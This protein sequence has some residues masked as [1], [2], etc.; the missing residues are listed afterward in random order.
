MK[1]VGDNKY[2]QFYEMLLKAPSAVGMVKGENHVYEM[3]NPLY[4][5]LMGRKDVIGKTVAEVFPEMEEQ[6]I[7]AQLDRVYQTGETYNGKERLIK[8]ANKDTG[9]YA[10]FYLD[11]VYQPYID[12][13]GLIAGVFFFIN[14]R[15]EQVTTKKK[16][17]KSES[18]YRRIVETAQEGIWLLDEFGRTTFVNK[19]LCEILEYSEVEM[20]GK[21]NSFFMDEASKRQ[22]LKALERRKRGV[23]ES[24]EY[25]FISKSGKKILTKVAANPIFDDAE[26]FK[27]SLGMVSDIT[28]KKHLEELLEKSNR[29]ARIGSWEIDVEKNTVYWSDITKE[30]REAPANFI[31]DLSTGIGFFTEGINQKIIAQRVKECM[32][33]G[34]PWDEE[35]QFKTFKGNLKWVRT[36]GEAVFTNGKCSKIYGCFQDITERKNAV[37]KIFRSEAKLKVAQT[38]AQV[39]S[40]EV[41]IFTNTHTWSDEIYRILGMD[42]SV[43]PSAETFLD[44]VH[45]DDRPMASKRVAEAFAKHQDSSFYFQF[46]KEND[47]LGYGLTEWRFEFDKAGNPLYISG[48]LR[49]LTKEKKAENERLKMISDLHQRNNDLEQ[50]SYIVSHNL[51]SPVANIIGL[52]EELKD[53]SHSA[54]V[55][56][57]LGEALISDAH[58]LENVIGDLNTILQTKTEIT[59]RKELVIFSDL[60]HDIELSISNLI[61]KEEVAITTDFSA[62][63]EFNTIKSY[64]Q[65]IFYNLI[66]N[67]I[68]FRQ[69]TVRPLIEISSQLSKNKLILTF[70][71]NGS[72]IDLEK[73]GDEVFGLY[74][75]FHADREGKG[76]G[77]YMVK[78]QVETLGGKIS[79]ASKVNS[80]TVFTVE[81]E[82]DA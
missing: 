39:G 16:I 47:E 8:V 14:D 77:L 2:N 78:T 42:K 37:N 66:S 6:G 31:P 50:F 57:I 72:G 56:K 10:D 54:E 33:N 41:D 82:H 9:G 74:K 69:P 68:K 55:K 17:E 12:N 43:V 25:K 51:R 49:D 1:K 73:K 60:T 75:R 19:K 27:G 4:L 24:L 21:K 70:K 26:N 81:F 32:E 38:I 59:E 18:Q 63:D 62:I 29:L 61:Q 13:D 20:L 28:E 44:F 34:T 7:I 80:G 46:Y 11:Y 48:I 76:M 53:E 79:V 58:R 3:V 35:L 36:I 71:D 22:A 30:I 23:A 65:S 52:T 45:P 40:W 5:Q 67:S 15:T 64:L